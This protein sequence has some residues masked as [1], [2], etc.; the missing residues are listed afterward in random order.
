MSDLGLLERGG[1]GRDKSRMLSSSRVLYA[2]RSAGEFGSNN[3]E[4]MHYWHQ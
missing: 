3:A 2:L 1:E 4:E